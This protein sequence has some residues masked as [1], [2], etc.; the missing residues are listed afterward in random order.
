MEQTAKDSFHVW[1]M[2]QN[3][4]WM[5]LEGRGGGGRLEM[6]GKRWK[7]AKDVLQPCQKQN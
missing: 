3:I 2:Y 1:G 5:S 4:K 7:G 6:R